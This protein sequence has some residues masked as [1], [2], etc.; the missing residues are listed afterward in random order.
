MPGRPPRITWPPTS[1][2]TRAYLDQLMRT[3]AVTPDRAAALQAA[4]DRTDGVQGGERKNASVTLDQLD[5]LATQL[6]KDAAGASG[7]DQARLRA[8]AGTIRGRVA[9]LR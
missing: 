8:L 4:L 1:M 6:E 9:R 2:V 7:H 3:R 5:S